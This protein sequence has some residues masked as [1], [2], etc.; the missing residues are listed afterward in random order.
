M[1]FSSPPNGYLVD[2]SPVSIAEQP[3]IAQTQSSFPL[4][5]IL[6]ELSPTEKRINRFSVEGNAIITGGC[7]HLGREVA[8]ALLEHGAAGISL[9]DVNPTHAHI[10][11]NQ[12]RL[13]FPSAK[14]IIKAVDVRDESAVLRAVSET[15]TELGSVN[16]LLCLAGIEACN[17]AL[18][19]GVDVWR[20]IREINA[21]ASWLCAKAVARYMIH[22]GV[23]GSIVFTAS[24]SAHSVHFPVPQDQLFGAG[25]CSSAPTSPVFPPHKSSLAAEWARYG[26]R[27]NS[28]NPGYMDSMYNDEID[29][30]EAR[31]MWV[32]RKPMG[33][34]GDHELIG[35][36]VLLCSRAGKYINGADIL[37]DGAFSMQP[38]T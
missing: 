3:Y 10:S 24:L 8:R 19:V 33:K 31:R 14:I 35:I 21:V 18:I 17:R 23:G 12:L 1:N 2:Y 29:L 13:D 16:L 32:T 27:V 7:S 38:R 5:S 20:R 37:V 30:E 28:I 11:I 4:D 9:F 34:V 36:A 22:Q 15:A 25:L 6:Y 26:I